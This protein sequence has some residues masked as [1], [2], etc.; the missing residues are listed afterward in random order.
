MDGL[1]SYVGVKAG[2][3]ILL[4]G[5]RSYV[6]G[7]YHPAS[8]SALYFLAEQTPTFLTHNGRDTNSNFRILDIYMQLI[9][10][11]YG[12]YHTAFSTK[13]ADVRNQE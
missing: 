11:S 1:H 13:K 7:I 3:I 5:G 6:H 9:F 2:P 12:S 8:L 10:Y 4:C